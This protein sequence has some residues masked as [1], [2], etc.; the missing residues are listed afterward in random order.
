M[1]KFSKELEAQLIPEWKDAFLNYWQLKKNIKKIKLARK[2]KHVSDSNC[3][4]GRSIFDPIRFLV[5][6]ISGG[7][8][9]CRNNSEIISQVKSGINAGEDG[10][11]E[12]EVYETELVHF[13][14]E[15]NEVKVFFEMLDDELNKVNQFY[16][17]KESEFLERGELLNKQL[18]ILLDLKRVLSDRRRKNLATKKTGAAASGFLS[19]SNSPSGQNSDFSESQSEEY[20]SPTQTEDDISALGKNGINFEKPKKGKPRSPAAMRIE[21]PATTPTRTIAAVTSMLW[22]DLVN[23]PK[24]DGGGAG[25]YINRKKIQCAEKMIRGAFVELY[26]G[27]NLLKTYSSLNMIAFTKIL[28]KFDKVSNQQA[29]TRYLKVVKRSNFI[30]SDKVVRLMDEVESLFTQHFA[31]DDRKKAMKFLRPLRHKDSHMVTFFVGLFTGSFVTLFSVYAILAHLSGM[32]SP[33]AK[34]SYMETVYPLFS[35]FA[36]LSLHLFMYGCNLFMWKTTRINYNFIF[37]FHPNTSLKYR[38]AFLICTSL[39]TAVVGAMVIHLILLST[40]FFPHQVDFIPGIL[41]LCFVVLLICPLNVFYRPTRYCFL[42][43]IRNIVCS[44]FYKVLMVDFF[45]AD[46][47]TSQIPLLR[48][49][50]SAAC[51]FLAGS[52]KTHR[53]ETCKSGR[54]YREL[55]YVISFAPY[56]WRAMQCARRWFDESNIDHLANL[57]KYVS[58]MVAAGARITYARQPTELWMVI[59]L[60]TSVVATVYQLYWD[61]VKDWGLFNRKSK[62]PWLRDDLVLKNKSIYYGSIVLNL[63]LRVAWVETVMKFNI[64]MFESRLLDF[65]LASIEVI[66]RG[67]WNFYRLENEHLNNVGKFRAVKTVPLPF[68]ETGC[69]G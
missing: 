40:G 30:S 53:Y 15:E 18:Q 26:R 67:H 38:D 9:D 35:M 4:F 50:E 29:S 57:G 45:M 68:R 58:A 55:A 34:A 59:V 2:P 3:D 8:N 54:L 21:I 19:R 22:E 17:T 65:L 56:Y 16:K 24:K 44:P 1:V 13:F 61:F 60:V 51:Y 46:Q 62:N 7:S 12:V 48:H 52:F 69:A 11:E 23:N 28:K 49:M 6:K 32:F 39:M 33:A 27:L 31:N 20:D 37:E 5:G 42:R 43:V 63:V 25:E 47:L 36:L 66:R 41:L 64:G 10:E 14:T